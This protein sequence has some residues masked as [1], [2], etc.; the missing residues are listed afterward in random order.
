MWTDVTLP[1]SDGI[2]QE[3]CDIVN[4]IISKVDGV[5]GVILFGSMARGD[6]NLYS[7]IDFAVITKSPVDYATRCDVATDIADYGD[8]VVFYTI[9]TFVRSKSWSAQNISRDGVMLWKNY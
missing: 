6:Y 5:L 7:D 1:F 3:I 9:G 4:L 8:D 2:V